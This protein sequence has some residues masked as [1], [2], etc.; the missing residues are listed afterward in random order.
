MANKGLLPHAPMRAVEEDGARWG[1]F[2]GEFGDLNFRDFR[3]GGL[4]R[5]AS[6]GLLK[7]RRKAWEHIALFSSEMWM[8]VAAVDA[9]LLNS[10][11]VCVVDKASGNVID[12]SKVRLPGVVHVPDRMVG[13]EFGWR[14]KDLTISYKHESGLV[15]DVLISKPGGPGVVPVEA[16]LH[17]EPADTNLPSLVT[18]L[19]F[20]SGM[21][22]YS[23]KGPCR[24]SGRVVVGTKEYLM[25]P[26]NDFVLVDYH[27]A[28]Y[29]WRTFWQWVTLAWRTPDGRCAALNLTRNII[30]DER[31]GNENVLW[32][33]ES[34][35]EL[36]PARFTIPAD[37]MRPWQVQTTDGSVN[38]E[39]KHVANRKDSTGGGPISSAYVQVF[40]HFYGSVATGSGERLIIDGAAGV[41]EDHNVRW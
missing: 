26:A 40:G 15:A 16:A 32:L 38:L 11:F 37:P 12:Y 2:R 21:P 35:E 25:D 19:P 10:A 8:S 9:G 17:L 3:L 22:F 36:A 13:A 30:D 29:P 14:T 7:S 18:L 4:P 39:F 5:W 1:R 23:L 27:R 31:H 6:S 28:C 41:A 33:G 24:V 34:L 20:P